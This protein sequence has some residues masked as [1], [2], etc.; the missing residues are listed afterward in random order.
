MSWGSSQFFMMHTVISNV[1]SL[2]GVSTGR[3]LQEAEKMVAYLQD[4][5]VDD[6]RLAAKSTEKPKPAGLPLTHEAALKWFYKDP[7]GE[8]QGETRRGSKRFFWLKMTFCLDVYLGDY[9][10][11]VARALLFS[12]CPLRSVQ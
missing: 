10:N 5:G 2:N 9:F 4:G 7:Q 1:Q 3:L 11:I 6:D 8:I 12:F